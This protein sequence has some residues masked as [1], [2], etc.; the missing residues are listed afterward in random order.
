MVDEGVSSEA[1]PAGVEASV[2]S[3]ERVETAEVDADPRRPELDRRPL[4][5]RFVCVGTVRLLE[6]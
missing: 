6:L 4:R 3:E 5:A 1:A 2:L